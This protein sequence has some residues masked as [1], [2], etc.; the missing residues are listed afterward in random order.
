MGIVS[1]TVGAGKGITV[2]R[3]CEV[4]PG[5][6]E[7]KVI[8]RSEKPFD[9]ALALLA[10]SDIE[11]VALTGVS[12]YALAENMQ[13]IDMFS[14]YQNKVLTVKTSICTLT[15]GWGSH[16]TGDW[17]YGYP[18]EE[19]YHQN[20]AININ[21]LPG[22]PEEKDIILCKGTEELYRKAKSEAGPVHAQLVRHG[23]LEWRDGYGLFFTPEDRDTGMLVK[24]FK[25]L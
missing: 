24:G 23:I 13:A 20:E 6:Q 25:V 14:C 4:I 17:W 7:T 10:Q 5:P 2:T 8:F 11:T 16:H 18:V 19:V 21:A 15:F 1:Y 12:M 9:D 3:P 22:Y